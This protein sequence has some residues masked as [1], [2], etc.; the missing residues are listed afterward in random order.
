MDNES[1]LVIG[2]K[3]GDKVA[4]GGL[5][6]AFQGRVRTFF[7]VRL[8][9]ASLVDDLS[10]DVFLKA[11]QRMDTFDVSRPFYPWLKGIAMNVLRNEFRKRKDVVP[12]SLNAVAE[13]LDRVA[14]EQAEVLAARTRAVPLF[15]ILRQCVGRLQGTAV[16]MIDARY[17]VGRSLREIGEEAGLNERTVSVQL[18]RIRQKLR[19]C[20]ER[21]WGGAAAAERGPA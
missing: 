19:E 11:Y 21:E 17:R 12:E 20:L 14:A 4:F 16:A 2:A 18:A 13:A 9:D 6:R 3:G 1:D 15:E 7:A 8:R 5:V 10:Q